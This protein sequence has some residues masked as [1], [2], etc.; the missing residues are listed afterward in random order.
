[1]GRTLKNVLTIIAI[2]M[3]AQASAQVIFYENEGY[4]GRSFNTQR[5]VA[6]LQEFGFN[7]RAS[8]VAVLRDLWEVCED[9][10]YRGRCA[11]LRP[12]RYP[13]LSAMGLNNSAS[14]V[15][16]VNRNTRIHSDRYAPPTEPIYDNHRRQNERVYEANVTTLHAVVGPPDRRCWIER[17]QAIQERGDH[18]IPAAMVGAL[19][20]G[21]LSHQIGKRQ[22]LDRT[23]EKCTTGPS[24]GVPRYWDVT[25]TFRGIEHH[26]QTAIPPGATVTV[27]R[28]GEPRA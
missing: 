1:M 19:I 13:S 5:Q 24:R 11:V 9:A 20:G 25:Y 21:V 14:S 27:N 4:T 8:S 22:P 17:E 16:A 23:V 28:R 15:R 26:I 18:S 7:D 10:R 2:A 6:N 12:G 3:G